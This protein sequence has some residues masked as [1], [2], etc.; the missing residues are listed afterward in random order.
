MNKGKLIVANWKMNFLYK[1]AFN[2]CKNLLLKKKAINN[3]FI[4]CPS[5]VLISQLASK[6]KNIIFGAQDC[7]FEKFGA[8]TGDISPLML[9]DINCKY[10]IIGHSERRLY[11]FEDSLILKKKIESVFK[12][13]L[14]QIFCIGETSTIRRKGQTKKYLSSQ[15]LKVLPKKKMKKIII[16]YEPIWAIGSGRTPTI[17]EIEDVNLH[18]RKTICKINTLYKKT[19]I[20]YGGSVDRKNSKIFLNNKNIDGLLVGGSSLNLKTFLTILKH[21]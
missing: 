10:V 15:L 8:Y 17:N 16:A 18:I 21:K 5:S 19:Q 9:K 14:I 2:F 11:H 4:I 3:S 13:N 20:L 7:H 12:I 1:N 6:F